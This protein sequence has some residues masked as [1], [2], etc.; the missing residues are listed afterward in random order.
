MRN[1]KEGVRGMTRRKY[2]K[3]LLLAIPKAHI[4]VV[5]FHDILHFILLK[6]IDVS[7]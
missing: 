7:F 4:F 2:I 5:I 6:V 3:R 1:D